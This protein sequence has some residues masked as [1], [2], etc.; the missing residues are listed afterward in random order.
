MH[1]VLSFYPGV[2]I[3]R[4]SR[5]SLNCS[6]PLQMTAIAGSSTQSVKSIPT[7][8]SNIRNKMKIFPS[9]GTIVKSISSVRSEVVPLTDTRLLHGDELS[10][11]IQMQPKLLGVCIR[12]HV[13]GE[14]VYAVRID[15][16]A[17]DYR[18]GE[19]MIITKFEL[20][21]DVISWCIQSARRD[22]L[23]FAGIDFIYEEA[24]CVFWC[25]EI[26]P[27]PGYHSFEKRLVDSGGDPIISK[28]LLQQLLG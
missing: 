10:C 8:L 25:L 2:V 18:Y 27:S 15:G 19:K 5:L 20:P 1:D 24:A 13:C 11:P 22:G 17:I 21:Q 14:A 26:N 16:D 23:E 28:W 4:P 3:N 12:A 7:F 6:K 9:D